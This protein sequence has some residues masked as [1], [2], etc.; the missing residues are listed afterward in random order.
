M[1]HNGKNLQEPYTPEQTPNP[2]Q[3]MDPN[4]RQAEQPVNEKQKSP[5]RKEDHKKPKPKLLGDET[6]IAD[7]TTI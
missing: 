1:K 2:P 5:A 7:E 4:E 6:E 3:T